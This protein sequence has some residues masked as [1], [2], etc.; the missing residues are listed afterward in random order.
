MPKAL[1]STT[2]K[3]LFDFYSQKDAICNICIGSMDPLIKQRRKN[4]RYYERSWNIKWSNNHYNYIMKRYCATVKYMQSTLNIDISP[5]AVYP[6]IRSIITTTKTKKRT[7]KS[8]RIMII[9]ILKKILQIQG[10]HKQIM[11]EQ[12]KIAQLLM[13]F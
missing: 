9:I 4:T 1:Q 6:S 11:K 10:K 12:K 7:K 3:D 2:C 5:E 13:A 8:L